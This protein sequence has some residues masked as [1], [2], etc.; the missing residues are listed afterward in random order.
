METGDSAAYGSVQNR[1]LNKL[2]T[3]QVKKGCSYKG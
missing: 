1:V 3:E 2:F